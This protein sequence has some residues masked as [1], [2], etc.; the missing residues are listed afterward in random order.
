MADE[1]SM[2]ETILDYNREFVDSKEYDNL[3]TDKYPNKELAILTC[4]D[5]RIVELLPK[6]MGLKNGDAKVIKNAGALITHPWGAVMRSLL[7]A[8]LEFNVKEIMVIGHTDCGMRGFDPEHL[9]DK[10]RKFGITDATI[11]T[12]R[13]A[14]IDLDGWL[15]GFD[16]VADSVRFTVDKIRN[17]PLMPG[18]VVVHGLVIHPTTGKLHTVVN[19]YVE[20]TN[21]LEELGEREI[22]DHD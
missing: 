5:A 4:M 3:S 19:G 9:L 1:K 20:H 7:V 13:N 17:H 12:L 15:R 18:R 6:A 8:A 11:T 14:G 21:L 22:E 10:A 2:L 16:N